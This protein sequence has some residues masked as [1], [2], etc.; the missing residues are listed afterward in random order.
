MT[1]KN[2]AVRVCF[3]GPSGP[4]F[5]GVLMKDENMTFRQKLKYGAGALVS[6]AASLPMVVHAAVPAEVTDAIS[7][8]KED[9]V[10]VAVAFLVAIIAVAAIKFLRS[11][12]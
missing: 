11:A 12:K 8:M 5:S 10:A 9:G 3:N 2:S 6:G 4:G 1:I 7:S